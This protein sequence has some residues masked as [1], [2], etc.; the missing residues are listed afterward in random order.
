MKFKKTKFYLKKF[1]YYFHDILQGWQESPSKTVKV[2][3]LNIKYQ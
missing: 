3:K 2:E 1:P